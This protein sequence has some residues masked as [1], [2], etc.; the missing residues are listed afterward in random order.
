MK[1]MALYKIEIFAPKESVDKIL[2]AIARAGAGRFDNYDHCASTMPVTGYW[3]P[4]QGAKPFIGREGEIS[5][6]QEVKIEVN[7]KHEH[8]PEVLRAIYENHPYEEPVVNI[9]P[10]MNELFIELDQT[11][12]YG[13]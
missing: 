11:T 7:C 4:H 5:S 12:R 3:R 1:E 2:A 9:L 10:L 6:E 13:P 8:I